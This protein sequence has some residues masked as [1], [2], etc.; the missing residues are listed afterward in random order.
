[1]GTPVTSHERREEEHED[2][3]PMVFV[4]RKF[5]KQKVVHE[6]I[7]EQREEEHEESIPLAY[8][9]KKMQKQR[10]FHEQK[11]KELKDSVLDVPCVNKSEENQ[12]IRHQVRELEVLN[13]CIKT[14][15]ATLTTR[16]EEFLVR[17]ARMKEQVK[18]QRIQATYVKTHSRR[19]KRQVNKIQVEGSGINIQ[20][21]K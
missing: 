14:Q 19:F 5:K 17:V 3:T 10:K 16:N 1:M 12:K 4:M 15:N 13:R 18:K 8:V 11:E 7:Q 20:I 9:M 21:Q 2:D 6:G